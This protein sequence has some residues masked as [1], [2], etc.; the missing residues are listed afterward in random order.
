MWNQA[1]ISTFWSAPGA[2]FTCRIFPRVEAGPELFDL[3]GAR[4]LLNAPLLKGGEVI[5]SIMV[6]RQE[7]GPFGDKQIELLQNF[8]AQAV[9]A[10]ENARLLDELRISSRCNSRPRPR[11]C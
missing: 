7:A 6:Y 1:T 8:A 9:I 5:G 3:A 10:I 2:S 4:A 11:R